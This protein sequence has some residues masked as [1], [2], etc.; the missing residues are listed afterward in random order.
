MRRDGLLGKY[1]RTQARET[2]KCNWQ[3]RQAANIRMHLLFFSFIS[4]FDIFSNDVI[5]TV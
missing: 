3:Q 1:Y 5:R 4:H 2:H